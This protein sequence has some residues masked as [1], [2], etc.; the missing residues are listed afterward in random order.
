LIAAG[1]KVI[2]PTNAAQKQRLQ[3]LTPDH[4]TLVQKDETGFE[5]I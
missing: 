3:A 4:V 5:Q 2:V 1:F